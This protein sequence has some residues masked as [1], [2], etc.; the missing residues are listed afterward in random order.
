MHLVFLLKQRTCGLE[1]Q[2][3]FIV[4]CLF[5]LVGFTGL[6]WFSV[7][8]NKDKSKDKSKKNVKIF[9]KFIYKLFWGVVNITLHE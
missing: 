9:L 3:W 2:D 8:H 5:N 4:A 7:L 1:V 6:I